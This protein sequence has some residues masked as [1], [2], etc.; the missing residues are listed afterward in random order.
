MWYELQI[1]MKALWLSDCKVLVG[2]YQCSQHIYLLDVDSWDKNEPSKVVRENKAQEKLLIWE[3]YLFLSEKRELL[4][5][6][7]YVSVVILLLHY[8]GRAWCRF[9][10][11]IY[12]WQQRIIFTSPYFFS[13]IF[14]LV[15]RFWVS[16]SHFIS[17]K[18]FCNLKNK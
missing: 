2:H 18:I 17:I 6:G 8:L 5:H 12:V 14:G 10:P 13:D 11:L 3:H 1:R 9:W 7:K 15:L 16:E 4:K